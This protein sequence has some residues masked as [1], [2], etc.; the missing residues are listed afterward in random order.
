MHT[1]A[2]EPVTVKRREAGR[3]L[4]AIRRGDDYVQE[5]FDENDL[6]PF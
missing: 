2:G 6:V 1:H 5:W 3:V 4:G